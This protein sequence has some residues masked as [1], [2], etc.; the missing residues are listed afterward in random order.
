MYK[1]FFNGSKILIGSE[2]K[3]SLNN[4]IN[5]AF[6][7]CNEDVVSQAIDRIECSA[8]SL[9]FSFNCNNCYETWNSFKACFNE[10]AAAGGVVV[11]NR[12][13][14][15]FI[16]R[17]GYWDLPKGKIEENETAE[18]AA[19]REVEEE[20]G[21]SDLQIIRPLDS[22]YHIYRSPFLPLDDNLVLK[23]TKWF[24]MKY[25]GNKVPVPQIEENIVE[26][27]WFNRDNLN[28]VYGNIYSNLSDFLQNSLSAI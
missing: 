26:I 16:K 22:T 6:D 2:M 18:D 10:I 14:I 24:L 17:F 7:V 1:V 19:V 21:I 25:N 27:C 15:L 23:E 9:S 11:N 3:K 28:E 12:N 20:C 8:D 5:E 4:N 13:E